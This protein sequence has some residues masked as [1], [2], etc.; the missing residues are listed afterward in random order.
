MDSVITIQDITA[1]Y[2]P[3]KR[4]YDYIRLVDPVN[5]RV[6]IN[7]HPQ[8][9]AHLVDNMACYNFW[10]QGRIC[11][12]CI[13]VRAYKAGD[14]FVKIEYNGEKLF[15]IT[16]LT[17][18]VDGHQRVLEL[19]KDIGENGILN[20]RG[21]TADE[22]YQMVGNINDLIV[23]DM[24]TGTYNKRYAYERL[25]SEIRECQ[26]N[27][28]AL[29][30]IFVSMD[31]LETV[32][33]NHGYVS[34]DYMIKEFIQILE[35]YSQSYPG[36]WL[37]R[38]GESE[39]LVILPGASEQEAEQIS[40]SVSQQLIGAQINL[41]GKISTIQASFGI[42][43]VN[44]KNDTSAENLIACADM[45][46]AIARN[47]ARSNRVNPV[48]ATFMGSFGL[49]SRE[50]EVA[51]LLL[52]GRTNDDIAQVLFVGI[53]TVKKHISNIYQKAQVSSR[54]EFLALYQS[55]QNSHLS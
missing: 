4:L 48:Y 24:L 40:T 36:S 14:S 54:S 35:N 51:K 45:S 27:S 28:G 39:F 8:V 18:V 37:A 17:M 55:Y 2:F 52:E 33:S 34:G 49:S 47:L 41:K 25:P 11:D 32:K 31:N 42:H 44:M 1:G 29:S 23:R 26:R 12:N 22:I 30:V 3:L 15:L 50:R 16:A 21:Q 43:T 19:V 20:V 13:S 10:N 38:F 53:P 46:I 7:V 9:E 6:A 5:K